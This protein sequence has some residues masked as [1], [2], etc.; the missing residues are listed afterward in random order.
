MAAKHIEA[1]HNHTLI[2]QAIRGITMI[3]EGAWNI[4]NALAGMV[5]LKDG[6]GSQTAHF[7][8]LAAKCGITAADYAD[9]PAAAKTLFDELNSVDGNLTAGLAAAEQL[10]AYLGV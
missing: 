1:D 7:D 3:R 4:N 2:R 5:A 9:A 10:C 6:D 8:L